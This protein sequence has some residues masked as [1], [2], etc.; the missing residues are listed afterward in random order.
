MSTRLRN[1]IFRKRSQFSPAE[2]QNLTLAPTTPIHIAETKL[3]EA[4][5]Y[6]ET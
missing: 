3:V 5:R 2:N 4:P 6:S 1:A